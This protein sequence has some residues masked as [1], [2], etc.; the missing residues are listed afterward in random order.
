V[1]AKAGIIY[2]DFGAFRL[3]ISADLWPVRK[4]Q[5]EVRDLEG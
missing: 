4:H 5:L 1:A 2:G 3:G